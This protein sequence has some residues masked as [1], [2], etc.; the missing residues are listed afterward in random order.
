MDAYSKAPPSKIKFKIYWLKVPGNFKHDTV[1]V[2][3][4]FL[5]RKP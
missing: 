4:F 2:C 3:E 5:K 1:K